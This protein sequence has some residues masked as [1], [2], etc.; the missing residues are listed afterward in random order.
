M[1]AGAHQPDVADRKV[2]SSEGDVIERLAKER[3]VPVAI[4]D[5]HEQAAPV[6]RALSDGG[7][8]CIEITFRT[9]AAA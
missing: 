9:P 7:L 4:V 3:V 2:V 8:R 5:D 1:T 6:C